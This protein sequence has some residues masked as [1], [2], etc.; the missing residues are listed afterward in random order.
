MFRSFEKR[1]C[2]SPRTGKAKNCQRFPHSALGRNDVA[3][4]SAAR[5]RNDKDEKKG[6]P[7]GRPYHLKLRI[8]QRWLGADVCPPLL[9]CPV[10][11]LVWP[12][13]VLIWPAP[14]FMC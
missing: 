11:V 2:I 4:S 10:P 7:E 1:I 14:V 13:P 8:D 6:R 3:D 5:R 12:A 9:M